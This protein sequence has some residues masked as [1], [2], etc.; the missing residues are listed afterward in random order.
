[1]D[2]L[3]LNPPLSFVKYMLTNGGSNESGKTSI[4]AQSKNP[5][6]IPNHHQLARAW[7]KATKKGNFAL[8]KYIFEENKKR[9]YL[10]LPRL[11]TCAILQG[12]EAEEVK[13]LN[14][15]ALTKQSNDDHLILPAHIA[16]INPDPTIL[17]NYF[18]MYPTALQL[19]AKGRDLIHYA[20]MNENPE[21]L[22]FLI[23]KR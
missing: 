13:M 5:S 17:Q 15:N 22:E 3:K 10:W 14:R 12:K 23:S 16:C 9:S 19:D 18:R 2:I 20:V 21:I 6:F 11:H 8:V 7:A 4:F 1:M